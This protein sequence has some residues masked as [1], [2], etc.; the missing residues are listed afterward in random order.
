MGPAG[1]ASKSS[2]V[3]GP[4][5]TGSSS[6]VDLG[7]PSVTVNV[8]PSGL[9]A[10][11]AKATLETTGGEAEVWLVDGKGEAPQITDA[12]GGTLYT[13]PESNTGTNKFNA[14]LSTDYV[15]P[16]TKVISLQFADSTGTATFTNVELVVIPL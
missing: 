13:K 6:R 10:Y 11:S 1:A 2:I 4:L 3:A 7:G 15:G 12:L 14:G 8:G 5:T 9:I 16:G